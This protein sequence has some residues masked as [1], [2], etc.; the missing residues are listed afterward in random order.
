LYKV[1]NILH[2]MDDCSVILP[3][4]GTDLGKTHIGVSA[5]KEHGNLAW[6]RESAHALM[7]DHMDRV[8]LEIDRDLVFYDVYAS[9]ERLQW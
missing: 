9:H 5:A 4:L 1:G 2:S 6:P 7:V 8:D 3:K